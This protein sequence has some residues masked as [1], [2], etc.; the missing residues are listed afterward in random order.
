MKALLWIQLLLCLQPVLSFSKSGYNG[1]CPRL[2]EE[3]CGVNNI[4]YQNPCYMQQAG[5]A[6]A[7]DGWCINGQNNNMPISNMAPSIQSS[8]ISV[9]H[10]NPHSIPP[11][12]GGSQL[13][14]TKWWRNSDN[15]YLTPGESYVGCPCN[16]SLLPVCGSNG[17][18]YGNMCRAECANVKAV[19]YGEC[20]DYNYTWPGPSSCLC[21]FEISTRNAICG[22]NGRSYESKCVANCV[23]TPEMGGGFCKND[24]GCP[25]Y[26]KPVCGVDGASYD[27][28]CKMDC[29]GVARLHEG[30]CSS[31]SVDKCYFCKGDI[32]RV[33]GGDGVTYDNECFLK[34]KG[35]NKQKDGRCPRKKGEVCNCQDV[36]LPVCGIDEVTYKNNC[37][38][39]CAGMPKLGNKA[40][41]LYKREVNSCENKCKNQ[42]YEPVCGGGR[43]YN[44]RCDAQCGGNSIS[45]NGP[46][47]SAKNTSHCVCSDEP[48]PVCG[49]D[50]RDYLNKCAL[51]CAG[52]SLSWDGPCNMHSSMSGASFKTGQIS[53]GGN[54]MNAQGNIA[55]PTPPPMPVQ[56]M[57]VMPVHQPQSLAPSMDEIQKIINLQMAQ[58]S[59][60]QNQTI[61][62]LPPIPQQ[63]KKKQPINVVLQFANPDGTL[64][65]VKNEKVHQHAMS[66]ADFVSAPSGGNNALKLH[67]KMDSSMSLK[68]LYSMINLKPQSFYDYFVGLINKRMVSRESIMFKGLSL[69]K[70]LTYIESQFQI[71]SGPGLMV[72]SHKN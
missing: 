53:P 65:D 69:G 68:Q 17:L 36:D 28:T 43:T 63:S 34:C 48:M 39:E 54:Y 46:C 16:D 8:S 41:Y 19:K 6:R 2:D 14:L 27:N 52:V 66:K 29:K 26:F 40:C 9:T 51:Q 12:S 11:A 21:G 33:C 3:V 13:L 45:T 22:V 25:H 30:I 5:V 70:L 23:N 58:Q 35:A 7:Y 44:N 37:E 4:T 67:L 59:S 49:V 15:G 72:G 1:A 24:C 62:V 38:L 20:G 32:K 55:M 18:T 64:T 71:N 60:N 42:S 31:D 47:G 56:P 57:P 50:G 61:I 10:G